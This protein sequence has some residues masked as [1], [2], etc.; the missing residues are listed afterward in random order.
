MKKIALLIFFACITIF[1]NAQFNGGF[2][3]ADPDAWIDKEPYFACQ[4][5]YFYNGSTYFLVEELILFNN[6]TI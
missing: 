1:A 6:Y 3:H 4:N 2:Y 5:N